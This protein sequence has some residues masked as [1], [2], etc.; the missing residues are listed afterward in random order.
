LHR[1]EDVRRL[2]VAVDDPF[3][4]RVLNRLADFDEQVEPF[5]GREMILIAILRASL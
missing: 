5:L 4:V 3:L 1:D 2:D